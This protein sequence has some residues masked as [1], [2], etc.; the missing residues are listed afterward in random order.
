ML[1]PAKASESELNL[2]M[3]MTAELASGAG[4]DTHNNPK[5]PSHPVFMVAPI[6][7]ALPIATTV[8]QDSLLCN[9]GCRSGILDPAGCTHRQGTATP[10]SMHGRFIVR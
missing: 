4:S 3:P 10:F 8:P 9:I 6:S 2:H 1:V 7:F 5:K